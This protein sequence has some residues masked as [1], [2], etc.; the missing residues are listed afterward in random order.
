MREAQKPKQR[1]QAAL[2]ISSPLART[3]EDVVRSSTPSFVP[4]HLGP[5]SPVEPRRGV[6]G[7]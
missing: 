5:H 7:G 2:K 4:N 3:S 1:K 6:G